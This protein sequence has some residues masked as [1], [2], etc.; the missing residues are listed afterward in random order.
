VDSY[1]L[2]ALAL[3]RRSAAAELG[4]TGAAPVTLVPPGATVD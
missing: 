4:L 2:C 1:G 3:N